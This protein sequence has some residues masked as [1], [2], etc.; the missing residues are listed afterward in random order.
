MKTQLN[1]FIIVM[2]NGWV[3][4]G[5]KTKEDDKHVVYD[6]VS[7]IRVWGTERGLGQLALHGKQEGTQLDP[8]GQL[9]TNE[10]AVLFLIPVVSDL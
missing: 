7:N 1:R 9:V 6:D 8:C 4:V 10:S 2:T 5:T 3:F